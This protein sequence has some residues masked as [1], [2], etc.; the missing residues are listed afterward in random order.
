MTNDPGRPGFGP[1][2]SAG[3]PGGDP[4]GDQPGYGQP[5]AEPPHH[6]QHPHYEQPPQYPP[7]QQ[8]DQPGYEQYE[9]P[10]YGQPEYGQPYGEQPVSDPGYGN[11]GN[12][13]QP[14]YPGPT[15]QFSGPPGYPPD[16]AGYGGGGYPPVP[17]KKSRAG[18]IALAV[19]GALVVVLC[20]GTAIGAV[21]YY[22]SK[23]AKPKH[24]ATPSGP[25]TPTGTPSE[26]TGSPSIN[27][28]DNG[29][30]KLRAR[31]SDPLPVTTTELSR[32]A[33]EGTS[34]SYAKT[35]DDVSTDC[36]TAVDQTAGALIHS[37]GC[38]QTVSITAV[39]TA[40]GCVVTFGVL[41]MPSQEASDKVVNGM[42]GGKIGSFI[43]RRHGSPAEGKAGS[44]GSTW[45]FLMQ[46]YGHYVTYASGAYASGAKVVDHDSA[47]V[48]CDT[49]LLHV[50]QQRLDARG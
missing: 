40:K 25:A 9:Q 37:L 26:E 29:A 16:P 4:W 14:P 24:S 48:A 31:S 3:Q 10:G 18:L 38:T 19:V 47:M 39:N 2:S 45:W 28:T 23:D 15:R 36:A 30:S 49:D 12:G 5:A 27:P 8:Y 21:V 20:G 6:E 34:G 35:G 11:Q 13:P 7:P 1:P 43:P 50:V 42:S 33:Y 22:G 17:P 41:N 44:A 46:T 32:E